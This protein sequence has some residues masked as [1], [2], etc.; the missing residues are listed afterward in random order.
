MSTLKMILGLA[1]VVAM[2]VVGVKVIPVYFNNYQF[3]DAIKTEALTATY[4]TRTPDDIRDDV[5]KH[6]HDCDIP[7]TAKQVHVTRTGYNGTGSLIIEVNYTATIDLPGYSTTIEFN[8]STK[9]K[10]VF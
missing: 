8:P 3:E 7:L 5:I 1:V 6:A 9:N 4:S 2:I 10:G